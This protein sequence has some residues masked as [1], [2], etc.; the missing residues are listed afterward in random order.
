MVYIDLEYE[1]KLTF[2]GNGFA[3]L[4]GRVILPS[5]L[6]VRIRLFVY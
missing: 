1:L 5:E 2:I 3:A 4:A 6:N